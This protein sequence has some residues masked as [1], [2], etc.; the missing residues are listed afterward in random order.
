MKKKPVAYVSS[1]VL[2]LVL[3][4]IINLT[5]ENK[6]PEKSKVENFSLK[7][8]NG[9]AHSLA[10]YKKSKAIVLIFV[11]T[12]CPISNAYNTRMAELQ[13]KY[14]SKEVTFLGINSNKQESIS[15]IKSHAEENKLG[16]AVL[17][18]EKNIIADKLEASVTPEV[19][20]INSNFEVLYH[21][22]IDDSRDEGDITSKD[23]STALD[24]V[25]S[26]KKVSNIRTKAFG[27]TIKRI[28][29]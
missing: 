19:Y 20:V 8:Y 18:D 17:K 29:S 15:E 2:L 13:K 24:E 6:L 27:C 16:F 25:L 12:Q 26:G 3:A 14:S 23:L 28:D 9:K 22:R 21:G 5:A 7:D 10:D 1:V 4:F 11:S